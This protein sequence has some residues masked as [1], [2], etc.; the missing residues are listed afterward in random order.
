M[1]QF[2]DKFSTERMEELRRK[3]EESLI[4]SLAIQ[5]GYEFVDLRGVSISPEALKLIPEE[6]ARNSN[7]LAFEITRKKLS[8]AIRNPN[9]PN[10]QAV[11]KDLE[12]KGYET[13]VFMSSTASL[14]H[15]W[16]RYH[17]QKDTLA[18]KRGV[19][20]ID[21]ANIAEQAKKF[22]TPES[23][24]S[25][26]LDIRT[27]NSARRVSETLESIFA[28]ALSL[29]ASDI[30]IEPEENVIRLRFRLDG[31]L[32][33]II[34]LELNMYQRLMSRLKLLSGMI[35]NIKDEAQDGRF[36]FD[37][38]EKKIEVRSSVIPGSLGESIVMRLL[39][40]T[41]ASFNIETLGLNKWIYDVM[42]EQLKRPNGMVVTTGPTGSGKTTALY[43]F[44]RHTHNE[45]VKIIT[46]EDPVEYKIDGLVQTQVEEEYTFSS[47]LRSILRQDPDIIMVG[48]IRD[49]EVAE[50]AI[51]AAQ[52]GHLVF[53]TLHTN[54]AVGA[55][56]RMI[57]LGVDYRMIGSSVNI[58]IGQRLVRVL[59]EHCKEPREATAEET[60]LIK[61]IA[62]SHPEPPIVP[63]PLMIHEAKGCDSCNH[64]GFDGRQGVFEAIIV[65][66]A[67][68]AAIIRDPREHVILE[69]AR[70]QGIPTMAEDGIVKV[71][72]G[73]T[74]MTELR[75][76]VDLA[77]GRHTLNDTPEAPAD[78]EFDISQY[79]V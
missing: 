53:T 20:D 21:A 76:V 22:K 15:G 50:T 67:V 70:P 27:L 43:A 77:E 54:S 78:D 60:E 64:T 51:H 49:S 11:L 37:V 47:G 7:I 35:L 57:D 63:E 66:E 65:D 56:P 45:G 18:V 6:T 58:V 44:L 41:V 48:E 3:E 46:I 32:H 1:V 25:Y 34:D 55:F 14:E 68:E 31:V 72:A 75:R 61:K 30:H 28:G 29:G 16:K 23:V 2:D 8:V 74:S 73:S 71:I 40:P 69:A 79:T 26:I 19:L 24:S 12:Q 59:C 13:T 38:G 4:H 36:T 5:H 39:D 62:A 10:T 52:T 9:N 17:D 42:M 33:D